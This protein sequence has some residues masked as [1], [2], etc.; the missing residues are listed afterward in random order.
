MNYIGSKFRLSPWIKEVIG[1]VY[2]EPLRNIIFCDLFAGTG[3][4]GRQFK[5]EAGKII[6]NDTEFY[7]YVL[8]KNYLRDQSVEKGPEYINQLNDLAGKRGFIAE[9]YGEN[10]L[11]GRQFFSQGNA[12]KIDACRGEI[13][14]WQE[15]GKIDAP[16]FY[17]LLASLL[18]SAD[19]VAN[20]A[21][22]YGAYLKK[23]KASARKELVIE[24]ATSEISTQKNEV[25]QQDANALIRQIEGDIL[26]LDPP[27]NRRQYGS[28]YH[29]LN[30]IA[31]YKEFK[32]KGKTGLPQ[33]YKSAYCRKKKVGEVL[34]DLIRNARFRYIFL[35]Y[36][37]EGLLSLDEVKTIFEQ[38][39]HYQL[40]TKAYRRF[41]AD[42]KRKNKADST[43]EYLHVLEKNG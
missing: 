41:K 32:P 33:Y 15:E 1:K 10:G 29:L 16:L 18:K 3:I 39:G 13:Q 26:Y 9:E 35:S 21:S 42:S 38:F 24:P 2:P 5:R 40:E 30:T 6:A 43:F 8:L 12:E 34:K 31:H 28:N 23:I 37:N 7:S 11:A 4:V 17:F 20:T 25:Y 27:Y 22:V 19:K 36:N 14:K